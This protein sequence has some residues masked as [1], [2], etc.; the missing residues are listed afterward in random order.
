MSEFEADYTRGADPVS[1]EVREANPDRDRRARELETVITAEIHIKYEESLDMEERRWDQRLHYIT[2][3]AELLPP[4]RR[5]HI[6]ED[7]VTAGFIYWQAGAWF[8]RPHWGSVDDPRVVDM[9]LDQVPSV[10]LKVDNEEEAIQHA[11]RRVAWEL[12]GREPESA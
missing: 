3:P 9:G 1:A 2:C 8:W 5:R 4:Q 12:A 7:T 10:E 11:R 6:P